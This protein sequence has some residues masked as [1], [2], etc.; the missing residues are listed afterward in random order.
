MLQKRRPFIPLAPLAPLMPFTL[1][2]LLQIKL[3]LISIAF[4]LF[5]NAFKLSCIP[6]KSFAIIN[7][8]TPCPKIDM[9]KSKKLKIEPLI[10][11]ISYNIEFYIYLNKVKRITQAFFV[12]LLIRVRKIG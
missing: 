4:I 11:I 12:N 7:M 8:L 5:A 9:L 3:N 1:L 2:L 10:K 6:F